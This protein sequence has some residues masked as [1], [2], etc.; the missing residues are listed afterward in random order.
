MSQVKCFTFFSVPLTFYIVVRFQVSTPAELP[1]VT[2]TPK[3]E[4]PKIPKFTPPSTTLKPLSSGEPP[5]VAAAR[6]DSQVSCVAVES[7]VDDGDEELDQLLGLQKPV[8]SVADQSVSGACQ[9]SAPSEKG[10]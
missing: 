3:Q 2:L 7:A 5:V 9:E 6:S 4:T 1:A 10:G 8:S